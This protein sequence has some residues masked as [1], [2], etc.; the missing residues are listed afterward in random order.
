MFPRLSLVCVT[1]HS[2]PGTDPSMASS[3]QELVWEES[4]GE[5]VKDSGRER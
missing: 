5:V 2:S 3:F 1:C 4:G